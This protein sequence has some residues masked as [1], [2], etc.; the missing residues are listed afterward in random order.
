MAFIDET[1]LR[2]TAV[3]MSARANFAL[4]RIPPAIGSV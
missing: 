2:P 3:P 4:R 1:R